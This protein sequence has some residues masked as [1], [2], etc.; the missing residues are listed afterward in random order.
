MA[1]AN[2]ALAFGAAA[3]GAGAAWL[4]WTMAS[5]ASASAPPQAAASTAPTAPTAARGSVRP[6]PLPAPTIG[7]SATARTDPR[8]QFDASMRRAAEQHTG[9][10]PIPPHE[11]RK[12]L[13][14]S[15]AAT[16]PSTE[17]WT[18]QAA[19]TYTMLAA[20]VKQSL[21]EGTDLQISSP[22]CYAA[23]CIATIAYPTAVDFTTLA[24]AM[25]Q[26]KAILAWPGGKLTSPV[27]AMQPG[28]QESSWILIRPD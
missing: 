23:G 14:D 10:E 15:L 18:A 12:L 20:E 7:A 13:A 9:D 24:Q 3:V 28:R 26:T 4:W 8:A 17:P 22:H 21:P 5:S 2:K 19:P 27:E 16:G 6:E 25:S 1:I 11:V